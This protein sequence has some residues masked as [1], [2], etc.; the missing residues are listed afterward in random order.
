MVRFTEMTH[1]TMPWQA[2]RPAMALYDILASD[3]R[4]PGELRTA[5][6]GASA[7]VRETVLAHRES[8]G[9]EPFGGADY[10]DAAGPTVHF[11]VTAR[12]IDPWSPNLR[13]TDTAFYRA[14]GGDRLARVIA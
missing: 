9:F 3:G 1:E 7:A 4:L 8:G 2:D 13:E 11:P 6:A 14:V 10:A 12:Q 5:A